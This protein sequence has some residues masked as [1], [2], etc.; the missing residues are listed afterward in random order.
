LPVPAPRTV[1]GTSYFQQVASTRTTS[2]SSRGATTKSAVTA[3][4]WRFRIGLYQ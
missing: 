4:S 1:T 2:S 3:P